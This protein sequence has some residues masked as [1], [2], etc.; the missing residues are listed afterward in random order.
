MFELWACVALSYLILGKGCQ[1]CVGDKTIWNLT[2]Q[3]VLKHSVT[4]TV[5]FP[6][7]YDMTIIDNTESYY[8]GKILTSVFGMSTFYSIQ[9]I[10][11]VSLEGHYRDK[12]TRD[13]LKTS[14]LHAG[15]LV[16]AFNS[17]RMALESLDVFL[18]FARFFGVTV[19][20]SVHKL[21]SVISHHSLSL[22]TSIS[23]CISGQSRGHFFINCRS[24]GSAKTSLTV[25]ITNWRWV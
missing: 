10:N 15:K 20:W 14:V 2:Y 7:G 23:G 8:L 19:L 21:L 13:K 1:M 17:L 4:I 5:Q 3:A 9:L 6:Y 24:P 25:L 18:L 22:H 12:I 16:L 11:Y